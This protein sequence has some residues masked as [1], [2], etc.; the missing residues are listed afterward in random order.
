M[1]ERAFCTTCG[2]SVFYRLTAPGPMNGELHVGM[3]TLDEPSGIPL[4]EEIYIDRKPDGY[5]FSGEDRHQMTEAEVIAMFSA[6]P[7]EHP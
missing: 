2:S 4:T 1:A 7:G 5:S 3:G 6:P